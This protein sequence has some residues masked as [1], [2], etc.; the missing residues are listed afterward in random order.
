M[1][2]GIRVD[3]R[4]TFTIRDVLRLTSFFL[5]SLLT[6]FGNEYVDNQK[7]MRMAM[8]DHTNKL[9]QMLVSQQSVVDKLNNIDDKIKDNKTRIDGLDIANI[10]NGKDIQFIIAKLKL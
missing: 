5:I 3:A 7:Q 1:D 8:D 9:N 6:Y 4:T 2:R 10:Q